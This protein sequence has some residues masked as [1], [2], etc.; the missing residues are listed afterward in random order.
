M[1]L[2]A[3]QL[4][5]IITSEVRALQLEAHLA[6]SPEVL[7][8]AAKGVAEA[9]SVLQ[10]MTRVMPHDVITLEMEAL[11]HEV[12][13]HGLNKLRRASRELRDA[14]VEYQAEAHRLRVE[15]TEGLEELQTAATEHFKQKGAK[16]RKRD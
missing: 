15:I 5:E 13:F 10:G 3:R 4:R 2:T 12:G 7:E 9:E 16:D 14:A 11:A 6:A 1:R 8:A